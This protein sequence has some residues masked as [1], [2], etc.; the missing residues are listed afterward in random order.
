[1]PERNGTA[2]VSIREKE[3]FSCSDHINKNLLL[4]TYSLAAKTTATVRKPSQIHSSKHGEKSAIATQNPALKACV[5]L[6][7]EE[8]CFC[9][10]IPCVFF[11]QCTFSHIGA[12]E[13]DSIPAS[14]GSTM[15]RAM[16]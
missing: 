10:V 2:K 11:A 15:Q 4:T 7:H 9:V 12:V 6:A 3:Y 8:A 5:F 13:A 14:K 1:M 16:H